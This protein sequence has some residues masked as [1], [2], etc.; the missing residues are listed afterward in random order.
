MYESLV[1]GHQ[2]FKCLEK[3][4]LKSY[5]ISARDKRIKPLPGMTAEHD[6]SSLSKSNSLTSY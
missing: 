2:E 5:L 3:A 1:P 4:K 6:V